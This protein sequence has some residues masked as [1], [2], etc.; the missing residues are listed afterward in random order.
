[1]SRFFKKIA[2]VT[3][4]I[5]LMS[6]IAVPPIAGAES[7]IQQTQS[8]LLQK[9]ALSAPSVLKERLKLQKNALQKSGKLSDYANVSIKWDAASAEPSQIR[10]LKKKASSDIAKDVS[11]VMDDL[12]PL[13]ATKKNAK[14]PTV[15]TSKTSKTKTK[16]ERHVRLEQSY[17]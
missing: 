16:G 8:G 2:A 5:A 6:Q 1:M 7:R 12:S 11:A 13:Y 17:S 14:K 9:N 15:K 4:A 10:N 3:A